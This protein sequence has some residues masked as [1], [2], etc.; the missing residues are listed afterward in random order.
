[1]KLLT[2]LFL[3]LPVTVH[4][5][6]SLRY[7]G[8][9]IGGNPAYSTITLTEIY[10][11]GLL[12]LRLGGNGGPFLKTDGSVYITPIYFGSNN[13]PTQG[14]RNYGEAFAVY[15][16][17][18]LYIYSSA[19]TLGSTATFAT[20]NILVLRLVPALG[21]FNLESL[22]TSVYYSGS[23]SPTANLWRPLTFTRPVLYH[24]SLE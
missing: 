24:L 17:P 13:D 8:V 10:P 21:G 9:D 7:D 5:A 11:N 23:D 15:Q 4:A 1:M 3:L 6:I 16:E 14:V 19:L 20:S 2:A 22:Y 12:R 18:V